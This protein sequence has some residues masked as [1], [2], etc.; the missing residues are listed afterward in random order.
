MFLLLAYIVKYQKDQYKSWEKA[1]EWYDNLKVGKEQFEKIED[2]DD[3]WDQVKGEVAE[4]GD[5]YE[6]VVPILMKDK[7]AVKKALNDLN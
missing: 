3:F 4:F 6:I 2:P 5:E 1:I 7:A